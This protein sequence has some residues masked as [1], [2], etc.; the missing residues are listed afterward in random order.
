[1]VNTTIKYS[2]LKQVI[3]DVDVKRDGKT[4]DVKLYLRVK[5]P[6]IFRRLFIPMQDQEQIKRSH[7]LSSPF[8]NH[9]LQEP[10]YLKR[11]SVCRLGSA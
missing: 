10:A 6:P 1:M 4:A 7:I 2:T 9:I 8:E 11:G 5:S 3:V